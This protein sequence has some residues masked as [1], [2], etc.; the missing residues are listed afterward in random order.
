[1]VMPFV[2]ASA[3]PSLD[4]VTVVAEIIEAESDGVAMAV[5]RKRPAGRAT[6][7]RVMMFHDGPGIRGGTH[8]FATNLA[9][10]GFE[11]LVPDLYHRHGRMLG[12]ELHEREADPSLVDRLWELLRTLTDVGIQADLD[13]T[14]KAIGVETDEPLASIGFCVGARAVFRSMMR[15]PDM[16][17]AGAMWHPS[18]LVDHQPDSPHLTAGRLS[19]PLFI[20]IGEAD[21]M[22]PLSAHLPFIE[23]VRSLDDV[24]VAVYNGADHGYTWRG[25]PSYDEAA[26]KA[27]FTSTVTLFRRAFKSRH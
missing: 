13:A 26:A 9:N 23:A 17:V 7:P 24:E 5:L 27:S 15:L 18:F 16:F 2:L 22:Q 14:L 12:W 19:G 10:E 6:S 11:V 3:A 21:Q 25:W 1:M 20:G 4:R 8:E